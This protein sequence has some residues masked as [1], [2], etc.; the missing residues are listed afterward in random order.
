MPKRRFKSFSAV[1]RGVV[2]LGGGWQALGELT[3]TAQHCVYCSEDPERETAAATV[4][5]KRTY[6]LTLLPTHAFKTPP[7]DV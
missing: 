1:R 5:A 6:V 3:A 4:M 2:G 7:L